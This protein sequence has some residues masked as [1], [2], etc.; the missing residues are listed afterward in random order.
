MG[1]TFSHNS[2]DESKLVFYLG[3]I[4]DNVLENGLL[5]IKTPVLANKAV[6]NSIQGKNKIGREKKMI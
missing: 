1:Q 4:H 3:L 2:I 6:S 5:K